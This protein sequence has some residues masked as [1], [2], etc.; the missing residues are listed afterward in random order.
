MEDD[1]CMH[2]FCLYQLFTS[3]PLHKSPFLSFSLLF[4]IFLQRV[5]MSSRLDHE[6]QFKNKQQQI[7]MTNDASISFPKTTSTGD[8]EDTSSSMPSASSFHPNP[9]LIPQG[10]GDGGTADDKSSTACR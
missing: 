6:E 10:G 9:S 2:V 7:I 8:L 3:H 1:A 5:L 4:Y